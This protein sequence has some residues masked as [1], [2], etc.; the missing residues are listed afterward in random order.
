MNLRNFLPRAVGASGT[1]Q[2][3]DLGA[4]TGATA[5][6]LAELGF[7]VTLVDKAEAMLSLAAEAARGAGVS[8]RLTFQQADAA[9]LASLFPSSFFDVVVCHNMQ[10]GRASCRERV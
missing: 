1:S 5:P 3:L 4:G 10:I 8:D 2:A 9:D 7:H 6:C